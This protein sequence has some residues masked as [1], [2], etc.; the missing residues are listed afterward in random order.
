MQNHPVPKT[1]YDLLEISENASPEEA[2]KAYRKLALKN[3]PDKN[4]GD[5]SA[6]TKFK[7]ISEAYAVLSNENARKL[8]DQL[9][10]TSEAEARLA[11]NEF[12]TRQ[13]QPGADTQQDSERQR[14]AEA[15]ERRA[16]EAQ[17][18]QQ[19][20][21]Q[22]RENERRR[23]AE[24]AERRAREAR[25]REWQETKPSFSQPQEK[26]Q[27]AS[28]SQEAR[29]RHAEAAEKRR[30]QPMPQSAAQPKEESFTQRSSM[31]SAP[32]MFM[33][34]SEPADVRSLIAFLVIAQIIAQEMA[35]HQQAQMCLCLQ[36][37]VRLQT[38]TCRTPILIDPQ[39]ESPLYASRMGHAF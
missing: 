35:R 17:E 23:Y 8:Y 18:R 38:V 31:R 26:R 6:E 19:A 37:C 22:R 12:L 33:R 4:P 36:I 21:A 13:N 39:E 3:H 32:T 10:R 2:K 5:K 20:E 25:E 14:R 15:A 9:K 28:Q 29:E 7:E 1:Y 34:V 11:A 24:A 16:R 30:S 27:K